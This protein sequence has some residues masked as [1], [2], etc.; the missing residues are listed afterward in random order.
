MQ[1]IDVARQFAN[2]VVDLAPL[3]KGHINDT[4]LVNTNTKPF[5]LQKINQHVFPQPAKIME[6]LVK[7]TTH[8]QTIPDN[9]K[10]LTLPSLILTDQGNKPFF[11]DE[12]N[13]YWRALSYLENTESLETLNNLADAE[14]VGKALGL[15]HRMTVAIDPVE[16][17]DT[18]PGFHICP[19][20]L[21]QYRQIQTTTR[22]PEDNFCAGF[23]AKYQSITQD[24][25][26]AKAE[27]KIQIRIIHGDPKLNNFLFDT[28]SKQIVSL[29]DLDTVKPGLIHYDL[30]DC[31][32][33][34]SHNL[35]NDTF[36]IQVCQTLLSNY[37]DVMRDYLTEQDYHFI[38]PTI[39]LMP[40]ELGLRFYTD[41]LAGNR[42]FKV[43]NP[44]ENLSR[45]SAQFRLCENIIRREDEISQLIAK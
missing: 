11:C 38:Y 32:R 33:S 30:G 28:S 45:A 27:G 12:Q 40:F 2:G 18:L 13:D 41:Y 7:L 6:N 8:I 31:I 9:F 42:Y 14:E 15:F 24:L 25:E 37:L 19:D 36:M 3:G 43:D 10:K 34:C 5:V 39:R 16:M 20:Y 1:P 29:I 35:D 21:A 22:L 23:I 44:N 26:V 4:Y 17:H